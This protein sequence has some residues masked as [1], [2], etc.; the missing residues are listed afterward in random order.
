MAEKSM[1]KEIQEATKSGLLPRKIRS[2][3]DKMDAMEEGRKPEQKAKK[4]NQSYA[5]GGM[6]R[7][8]YSSGGLACRAN[9]SK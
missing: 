9:R 3:K 4:A 6:A 2:R 8:G 5:G 7:K 1:R